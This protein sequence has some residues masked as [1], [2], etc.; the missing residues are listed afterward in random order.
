MTGYR[1]TTLVVLLVTLPVIGLS[2]CPMA[3]LNDLPSGQNTAGG[4]APAATPTPGDDT[5]I[6]SAQNDVDRGGTFRDHQRGAC[7][8]AEACVDYLTSGQCFT[9]HGEFLGA[10]TNC[11]GCLPPDEIAALLGRDSDNDGA[12]DFEELLAGHDPL[13]PTDGPDIDGDGLPNNED[14]D[15]D[16]DGL[17]NGEDEDVDGDGLLNGADDDVDGDGVPN[18]NDSDI[19]GDGMLNGFDFDVDGD[20]LF[21]EMDFDIDADGLLNAL[22]PD[23]DG[24]F[25]LNTEDTDDDGDGLLDTV[26]N[27]RDSDGVPDRSPGFGEQECGF[28]G[29][30]DDGDPCTEDSC[31]NGAC[32]HTGK[33]CDDSN[34]C[35]EDE[36]KDGKCEHKYNDKSCD[37]NNKCTENDQCDGGSCKGDPI[38]CPDGQTCDSSSGECKSAASGG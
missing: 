29:D 5:D 1:R 6:G 17:L 15:V 4:D 14:P 21:N 19:D 9:M 30:C 13:D 38:S 34:D 10:D 18:A 24:D 22:D 25:L 27:D 31:V 8:L 36:C 2:G 12:N 3:G 35:T 23:I 20:G 11:A 16:G 26:D 28:H 37:D 33:S 32:D 7:C